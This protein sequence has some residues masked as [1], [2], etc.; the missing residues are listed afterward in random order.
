MVI[1]G[2]LEKRSFSQGFVL[3]IGNLMYYLG[4]TQ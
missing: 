3:A 4:Y 1:E 2:K